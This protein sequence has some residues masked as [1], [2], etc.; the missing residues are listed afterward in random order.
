[1]PTM[2][3]HERE[4]PHVINGTRRQR[5]ATGSGSTVTDVNKLLKQFE[6]MRKMM[7]MMNDKSKMSQ[8]MKAMKGAPGPKR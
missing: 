8:L 7:R 2:T 3:T 6:D 4:N 1:M 5:I